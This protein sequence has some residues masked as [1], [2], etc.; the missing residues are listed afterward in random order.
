ML[1]LLTWLIQ[2]AVGPA[3]LGLPV[4][5]S[6]TDLARATGRWFRR[7]Q[8][9]DGLSRIVRASVGGGVDL[10]ETEFAALRHLLEQESTWIDLGRGTVEDLAALIA[11]RLPHLGDEGSL[12]AGRAIAAGLLEFAAGDLEPEWFRQILLSRLD[13]VEADQASALDEALLGIHADLAALLLARDPAV[14]DRFEQEM[15]PL[16][17]VLDRLPPGPAGRGEVALYL[18]ALIRWLNT[19]SSPQSNQVGTSTLTPAAIE[20]KMRIA[21]SHGEEEQD[22]EADELAR[23]CIR[24]VVLG[25]PG[26]GKTWLARRTARLSAQA[27]LEALAAGRALDEVELPLYT[28]CARLS[29]TP[30]GEDIRRA[31]VVSALSQ[32]PG[33][34]DTRIFDAVR[35]LFEVRNAPTLLVA[36]SLDE[37]RGADDRIRQADTLPTGWRI[38]LTS[39]PGS[40]H[41]QL[42]ISKDDP[43]RRVGVLRPLRYPDDIE[44]FIRAWFTGRPDQAA[45][46]IA[47][48]LERPALQQAASV[49]L[50]LGFYCSIGG[51]QPLPG[52]RADLYARLI[53][54]LL[55]GRWRNGD[56]APDL[57]ACIETLRDWAWSAAA[58]DPVSGVG[59]WSDEFP[60]LPVR[61]S[62]NDQDALDDVAVP[63]GP[64]DVDTGI[65]L[66]GSSTGRSKSTWSPNTSPAE[67]PPTAPAESC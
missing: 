35:I 17:Q 43:V 21:S 25:D 33:L 32:L 48:L 40:W 53:R 15:G 1:P 27:A 10:S 41:H 13:R 46:L 45:S 50:I 54:Y 4:T 44:P 26:S 66:G 18:A 62:T 28:T 11:S 49:P 61:R 6:A 3:L 36:D 67:C 47:Q 55:T 34:A 31:A 9:S 60:A 59:A 12:A 52:R 16:Q 38:V 7:L 29:A 42:A 63:L 19:D 8:R 23:R 37:A 24:L 14:Q 64:P 30:P 39:R 51:D 56:Y 65:T 58:S 2:G 20:R 22:L 5:W 57:D